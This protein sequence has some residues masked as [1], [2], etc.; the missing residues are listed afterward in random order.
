MGKVILLIITLGLF[1]QGCGGLGFAYRKHLVGNYYLIAVD[2]KE[3]ICVS[4]SDDINSYW[5]ITG[6]RVY[7][8]GCN[9]D[10]IIAKAYQSCDKDVTEYYLISINDGQDSLKVQYE[11]FGPLTKEDFERKK[12]ELKVPDTIHFEKLWTWEPED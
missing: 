6:E 9:N 10:F 3:N 2:V 1:L 4:Y 5:N 7:E 8:A 11:K 12:I